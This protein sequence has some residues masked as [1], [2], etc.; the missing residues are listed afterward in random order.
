VL[1]RGR[2]VKSEISYLCPPGRAFL[3]ATHTSSP[4][5]FTAKTGSK[6]S[7]QE[8]IE[9]YLSLPDDIMQNTN[10]LRSQLVYAKTVDPAANELIDPHRSQLIQTLG[11]IEV[12]HREF[13]LMDHLSILNGDHPQFGG[14]IKTRGNSVSKKG[15]RNFHICRV[16]EQERCQKSEKE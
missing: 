4:P 9:G 16:E 5:F 14:E 3:P 15:N 7:L 6:P 10:A 12:C 2:Q 1:V 13:L 8:Q 11:K